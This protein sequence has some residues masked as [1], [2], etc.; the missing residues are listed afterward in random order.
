MV[1]SPKVN[2]HPHIHENRKHD[3]YYIK[4]NNGACKHFY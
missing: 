1:E 2:Q 3:D 4:H